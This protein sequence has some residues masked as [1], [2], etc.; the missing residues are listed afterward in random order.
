MF[1]FRRRN[2]LNEAAVEELKSFVARTL[3]KMLL[4]KEE[5]L[6]IIEKYDLVLV[7]SWDGKYIMG[8][9]YQF[10]KYSGSVDWPAGSFNASLYKGERNFNNQEDTIEYIDDRLLKGLKRR[11][12]DTFSYLCLL[13]STFDVEVTSNREYKCTWKEV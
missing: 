2:S 1:I 6:H 5:T 9:I 11:H 7:F 4:T 10:S 12:L 3:E 8:S 13:I